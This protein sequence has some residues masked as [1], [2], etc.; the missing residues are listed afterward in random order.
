MEDAI[1]RAREPHSILDATHRF[2]P[3]YE[4]RMSAYLA[5][6]FRLW[7]SDTLNLK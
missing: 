3:Q 4:D 6:N 1:V 5:P 2:W 7:R